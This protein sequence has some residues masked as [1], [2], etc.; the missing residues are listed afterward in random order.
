MPITKP[1]AYVR[2][3]RVSVT[4]VVA[5]GDGCPPSERARTLFSHV[6]NGK[7]AWLLERQVLRWGWDG[8]RPPQLLLNVTPL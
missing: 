7:A 5:P 1:P 2:H 4:I 6:V 3:E 8:Y